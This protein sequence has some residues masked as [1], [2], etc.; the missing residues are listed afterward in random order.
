MTGRTISHY[1]VLEQLGAGGMGEIYKAQDARLNRFVAIKALSIGNAGDP[2][3]RRR[4]I[5]EAQAA[6]ALNHPNIITV[7]DILSEQDTDYMVME[8]VIGKT[9]DDL[10]PKDGLGVAPTLRYGVQIADALQA[11]HAGGIIHRDLKPG[12]VMVTDSGLVKILDFG[13]AKMNVATQLTDGQL[14]DE[15]VGSNAAPLTVEGS[16]LG[17]VCYMSPEQAEGKRV[18][19]RSDVFSFG[20]VLYEMLT[21]RKAFTGDSAV[22]TLSAILRDEARPI[23]Q[24]VAGVPL[25]LEEIVGRALCKDPGQRWQSMRDMQAALAALRQKLESGVLYNSQ[26]LAPVEP[27]ARNSFSKHKSFSKVVP[28]WIAA[29]LLASAAGWIWWPRRAAEIA[30]PQRAERTSPP[31]VT[32]AP[33]PKADGVVTNVLTNQDVIEMVKGKVPVSVI[34]NQ[35][36]ASKTSFHLTTPD[37]INLSQNGV[38]ETVIEAMRAPGSLPIAKAEVRGQNYTVQVLAGLPFPITL[39]EDVMP[40]AQPGQALRFQAAKDFLVGPALVIARGA[41]VT[42][43]IVSA[44]KKKILG[45]TGKPAFRLMQA[46]AVDGSKLKVRAVPGRRSD[47]KAERSI[48][49]AGY[50][51]KEL[52]APAGS[53]YLAYVEG[54]QTVIVKK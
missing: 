29:G 19:P 20:A 54:D 24:I 48:E 38:P 17:T 35:I 52:L 3:R 46:D 6:S 26:V 12:N 5:Q 27:V 14:T 30:P 49:P 22:S 41:A 39:M 53:Q 42:G 23:S 25:E 34:I 43:Q 50:R 2:E 11:A 9:L 15:T 28:L 32:A 1:Q 21:G 47:D 18:D 4:F 8:Y 40:D 16:I 45:R 33:P 51:G 13:L 36:R 44:G 7:H 10:I 37:V 31:P